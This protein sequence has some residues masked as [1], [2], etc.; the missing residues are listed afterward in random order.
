VP[1]PRTSTVGLPGLADEDG[2]AKHRGRNLVVCVLV[3]D[4]V[5]LNEPQEVARRQQGQSNAEGQPS[6]RR[7][8]S[9]ER[10][11]L[12]RAIGMAVR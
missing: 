5:G 9:S 6:L 7:G 1:Q 8:H 11:I 4:E 3:L 12:R 10:P 2:Q